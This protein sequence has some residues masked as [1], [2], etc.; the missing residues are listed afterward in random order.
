MYRPG[1]LTRGYPPQFA[2][3]LIFYINVLTLLNGSVFAQPVLSR[4]DM[5]D[6]LE[7]VS[8]FLQ[9]EDG[10]A[11]LASL[12]HNQKNAPVTT[13]EL[14]K[15]VM[16][17]T[18][19]DG[20]VW[21]AA[22]TVQSA[23]A[24]E[25]RNQNTFND[26]L[27]TFP[28]VATDDELG[29]IIADLE[30]HDDIICLWRKNSEGKMKKSSDWQK[31]LKN[32]APGYT[33]HL[34]LDRGNKYVICL[35]KI[36]ITSSQ[37]PEASP[38]GFY[39][40]DH[41]T[42]IPGLNFAAQGH[43]ENSAKSVHSGSL[44][45]AQQ[46]ITRYGSTL[47]TESSIENPKY[48][49]IK[50]E[51]IYGGKENCESGNC[52]N[53]NDNRHTENKN[54]E[55]GILDCSESDR[56]P[57]CD[58]ISNEW[59]S[60]NIDSSIH[61]IPG[62]GKLPIHAAQSNSDRKIAESML[63]WPKE[64]SENVA[65]SEEEWGTVRGS[66]C[67]DKS[68]APKLMEVLQAII[69][70][71][72][73]SGSQIFTPDNAGYP[74]IASIKCP[75]SSSNAMYH[76][77]NT[78]QNGILGSAF[79]GTLYTGKFTQNTASGLHLKAPPMSIGPILVPD[80]NESPVQFIVEEHGNHNLGLFN[81]GSSSSLNTPESS[82]LDQNFGNLINENT[83]Q[84]SL[85]SPKPVQVDE[86]MF[87]SSSQDTTVVSSQQM[88]QTLNVVPPNDQNTMNPSSLAPISSLQNSGSSFEILLSQ[89]PITSGPIKP[90][91][92]ERPTIQEPFLTMNP[93]GFEDRP[94]TNWQSIPPTDYMK[95]IIPEGVLSQYKEKQTLQ[96]QT[97]SSVSE[98]PSIKNP[99][100]LF[101]QV[102]QYV[103]NFSASLQSQQVHLGAQST[104]TSEQ[105]N[106]PPSQYSNADIS[107]LITELQALLN[108]PSSEG[109]ASSQSPQESD[110]G[111]PL[112]QGIQQVA[113]P[114]PNLSRPPILNQGAE[115]PYEF[116]PVQ[117]WPNV[118]QG[119]SVPA[120]A[121]VENKPSGKPGGVIISE[122]NISMFGVDGKFTT[123][124]SNVFNAL[125]SVSHHSYIN[126]VR[127]RPEDNFPKLPPRVVSP[128]N[129]E[130]VHSIDQTL[131]QTDLGIMEQSAVDKISSMSSELVLANL[132][133]AWK[134]TLK[135]Q[136][137]CAGTCPCQCSIPLQIKIEGIRDPIRLNVAPGSGETVI[138]AAKGSV[139]IQHKQ[140]FLL[141]RLGNVRKS[142]TDVRNP[143]EEDDRVALG[144]EES[145]AVIEEA[146]SLEDIQNKTSI[147]LDR[148]GS[149]GATKVED[150]WKPLEE[151]DD[152]E[153]LDTSITEIGARI[154]N[155]NVE[156]KSDL[157]ERIVEQ[158]TYYDETLL[159]ATT[160][161]FE[162]T[163]NLE[164]FQESDR[165]V[166]TTESV[167][168]IF[169]RA[170]YTTEKP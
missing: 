27:A 76:T 104:E 58:S 88:T 100:V 110:G 153:I 144:S 28:E 133:N 85:T 97:I 26:K 129:I 126:Y 156:E 111:Y 19:E 107:V 54:I 141:N 108:K 34:A 166:Q 95:P 4:R 92:V 32:V 52:D 15:A 170:E 72:T 164:K 119:P 9:N 155:N 102:N 18:E 47:L 123:P 90:Q 68:K 106:S 118:N 61:V 13:E 93:T 66:D 121:S 116:E 168:D 162:E 50:G 136:G 149:T 12:A 23:L 3:L 169:P 99:E 139:K 7:V 103:P 142:I 40:E 125:P 83:I 81:T 134:N 167:N 109:P 127:P 84:S 130:Q 135:P 75:H 5:Q 80:K 132:F 57:E 64:F 16:G 39:A 36:N 140:P 147:L 51:S 24:D 56:S 148:L 6:A 31:L 1:K 157:P 71:P 160:E 43:R 53:D 67:C 21:R 78:A 59:S 87:G 48:F 112:L 98:Q 151:N 163:V 62:V 138:D 145:V 96:V 44:S 122:E 69:I 45:S 35:K 46:D 37:T 94:T 137:S 165:T 120:Y 11:W 38:Q 30:K 63:R 41:L 131:L 74:V 77:D 89:E 143:S 91:Q 150:A 86:N 22:A 105:N 2:F 158:V 117:L 79:E 25:T 101:S 49:E 82:I 146:D 20:E 17:A 8:N 115:Q 33:V 161:K 124:G 65:Q 60:K 128:I 55:K 10:A 152:A 14:M 42:T 154:E 113:F 70:V 73:D 114:E 159:E 29:D